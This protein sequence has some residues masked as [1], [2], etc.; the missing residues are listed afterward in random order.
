NRIIHH[1]GGRD[2]KGT[3]VTA[4]APAAAAKLEQLAGNYWSEELETRYTFF[5][6]EGRLFGLHLKH[7]E[8]PLT[9]ASGNKFSTRLWFMPSVEFVQDAAGTVTGAKLGGG[10]VTGVNF[11]RQGPPEERTTSSASASKPSS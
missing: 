5:L 1:Q 6:K 9:H 8:F 3:R 4:V 2:Q 7:G 11:V 10:R